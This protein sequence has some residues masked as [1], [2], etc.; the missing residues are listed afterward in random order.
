MQI[1]SSVFREEEGEFLYT[2][3]SLL[4]RRNGGE[5]ILQY[6]CIK[7][8]EG[9]MQ[10]VTGLYLHLLFFAPLLAFGNNEA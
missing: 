4:P 8:E 1:R 5:C 2:A 7:E 3:D 10:E 6:Y 9:G